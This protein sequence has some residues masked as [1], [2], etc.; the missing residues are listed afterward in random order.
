MPRARGGRPEP[1]FV[2]RRT[3]R[4]ARANAKLVFRLS[5]PHLEASLATTFRACS[6]PAPTSVKLQ[7]TP[8]IISQELVHIMSHQEANIHWSRT[9]HGPQS[10]R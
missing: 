1:W 3:E 10:P 8:A 9:T 7:P 4:S 6:S 2:G 5:S